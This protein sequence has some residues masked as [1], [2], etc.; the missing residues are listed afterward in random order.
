MVQ[1]FQ[2]VGNR[3]ILDQLSSIFVGTEA[4]KARIL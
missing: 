1:N 3:Q 4:K 2:E